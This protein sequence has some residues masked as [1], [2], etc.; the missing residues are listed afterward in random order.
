MPL[1]SAFYIDGFNLYHAVADLGEPFLKWCNLRRL[2][3][4][5]IPSQSEQLVRV[6]YCSAFY[7]GEAQ[8]RWRHEQYM[9]AL[10]NTDVNVVLGHFIKEPR[11]CWSCGATWHHPT[12]KETDINIAINIIEDA[13]N[14]IYDKIYLVTAD[15]DQASTARFLARVFPNKPLV[16]VAPPGRN[17]SA[18][19]LQH[20]Q[21]G[22]IKLN[23]DHFE[24]ALLPPFVLKEGRP[25]AR[26]PREYD[27]PAGWVEPEARPR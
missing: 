22:K 19:I 23:R 8:K 18:A 5:L 26:R 6:T 15:S 9:N 17:F 27:P 2:S 20:A 24:R 11:N 3:E 12:E 10:R 21:G 1:R 4:I 13:Y 14:D 7:P 16:T 25:A